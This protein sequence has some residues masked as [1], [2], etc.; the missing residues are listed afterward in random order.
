MD[1]S[2]HHTVTGASHIAIL[3]AVMMLLSA[4]AAP[5]APLAGSFQEITVQ[6]A[7]QQDLTGQRVRW[8]GMIV[9]VT[10]GQN[11]TCFEIVSRPLDRAA[12]PRWTD[13]SS[14]RFLACAQGFY[15]PAVYGAGRELTVVG[16]VQP[17]VVREIGQYD[18]RYPQVSVE[19]LYLWPQRAPNEGYYAPPPG[20]FGYPEW[21]ES[22]YGPYYGPYGPWFYEPYWASWMWWSAPIVWPVPPPPPHGGAHPG[23]PHPAPHPRPGGH[24]PPGPRPGGHA[25]SAPRPGAHPGSPGHG[26]G[27]SQR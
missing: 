2:F 24:P 13:Q 22:Y 12:R 15:D 6:Q 20:T 4:C 9:R 1:R 5:P 10:P 3:L 21:W 23:T 27:Q 11:D 25:P 8:G 19:Q 7:Q 17:S 14:G 26:G 18:Y 16:T